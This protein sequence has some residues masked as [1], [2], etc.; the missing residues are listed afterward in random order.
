MSRH[1]TITLCLQY[2]RETPIWGV[3]IQKIFK[4]L[5]ISQ[6][7]T[8]VLRLVH[9]WCSEFRCEVEIS[10]Q[11]SVKKKKN[12]ILFE[13]RA[14]LTGRHLE[15]IFLKELE[16]LSK[17]FCCILIPTVSREELVSVKP[18]KT[19]WAT[20]L[21]WTPAALKPKN[22]SMF[23]KEHRNSNKSSLVTCKQWE[24]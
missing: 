18:D 24:P 13:T 10:G 9:C 17:A 1:A 2:P 23:A 5:D 21:T 14:V 22:I 16:L 15:K 19:N 6:A 7:L 3:K 20:C 4:I 11:T 12:Y 8:T